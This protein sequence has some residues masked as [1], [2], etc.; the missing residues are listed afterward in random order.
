MDKTPKLVKAG[1]AADD[2]ELKIVK[3]VNFLDKFKSK[4]ASN[5]AGVETLLTALPII[6]IGDAGDFVRLHP[7]EDLYW[8]DELCFVSVPIKGE[9]RDLLH[10]IDEDVAM[11]HLSSKKVKRHRLALA[12]KPYDVL[13]LCVVPSINLDNSWNATAL[14]ACHEAQ[15]HWVQVLSRKDEQPSV[16]GYKTDRAKDADA[17]PA[18]KWS[19]RTLDE[20]IMCAFG[21]DTMIE[22][23]EHPSLRR[24]IGAK[25]NLT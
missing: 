1:E 8:S 13:F 2:V 24:L 23:S 16:E 19:T 18:P 17:F 11:A 5:I 12:T 20:L 4:R 9:K 6:K 7:D 10:L 14:K 15:T 21:N 3:P 25:Q 22:T